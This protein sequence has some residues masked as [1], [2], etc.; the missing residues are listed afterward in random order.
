MRAISRNLR[1]LDSLFNGCA[2]LLDD[3]TAFGSG[4][5]FAIGGHLRSAGR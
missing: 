1:E 4:I 3:E 5:E 2:K